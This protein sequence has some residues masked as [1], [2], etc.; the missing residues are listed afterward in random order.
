MVDDVC[1]DIP[2][3]VG[4]GNCLLMKIAEYAV[5]VV[6]TSLGEERRGRIGVVDYV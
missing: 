5:G 6:Q 1:L 3:L 4:F 2:S